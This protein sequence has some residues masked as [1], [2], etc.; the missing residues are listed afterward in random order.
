[1]HRIG[2]VCKNYPQDMSVQH[3][4]EVGCSFGL[5]LSISMNWPLQAVHTDS[6]TKVGARKKP[7]ADELLSIAV[8]VSN[9]ARCSS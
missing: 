8:P 9:N 7:R 6:D 2:D 1:M 3:F 4:V 5:S